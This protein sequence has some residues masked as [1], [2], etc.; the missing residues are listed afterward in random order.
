MEGLSGAV[1]VT[2]DERNLLLLLAKM[3][4]DKARPGASERELRATIARIEQSE[5]HR[6]D[7]FVAN[8]MK[9]FTH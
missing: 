8:I 5:S 6:R 3:V 9:G 1:R 7:T 2:P 4:A